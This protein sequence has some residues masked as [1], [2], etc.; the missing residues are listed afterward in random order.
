MYAVLKKLLGVLLRAGPVGWV[1]V[2]ALGAF[3]TAAYAIH[4]I[5]AL[6][7]AFLAHAS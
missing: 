4:Q 5:A 6:A 7:S 2:V 1:C 3:A